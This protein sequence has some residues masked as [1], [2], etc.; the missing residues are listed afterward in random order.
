MNVGL[1]ERACHSLEEI[2]A[3]VQGN[4]LELGAE[5]FALL[6]ATADAIEE[7]GMRLREQHDFAGAPL[8]RLLPRLEPRLGKR[9]MKQKNRLPRRSRARNPRSQLGTRL[10]VLR[11]RL[12]SNV[13]AAAET[14]SAAATVRVAAE[15]L[16][17]LL[18]RGG[19]LLVARRR[20]QARSEEL[21]SLQ[22]SVNRWKNEWQAVDRPLKKL[23]QT[24]G[25]AAPAGNGRAAAPRA[26][27]R[28]AWVTCWVGW[29][30][31]CGNWKKTWSG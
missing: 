8:T 6:F 16:D 31:N 25:D 7:A 29:V 23:L 9:N 2:L 24:N 1:L 18:A 17:V 5:V 11:R 26:C 20:V 19:E 10:Q 22:E 3:A 30:T 14:S 12:N 4:R 13:P 28:A 27:R 21:A 15:K